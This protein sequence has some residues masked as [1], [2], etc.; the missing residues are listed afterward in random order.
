[1]VAGLR[2]SQSISD[3]WQYQGWV[4]DLRQTDKPDAIGE[5]IIQVASDGESQTALADAASSGQRQ[6]PHVGTAQE[7]THHEAFALACDEWCQGGRNTSQRPLPQVG[8]PGRLRR[9]GQVR[10]GEMGCHDLA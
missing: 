1:L 9:S 7:P 6:E 3:R 4:T 5:D 2:H 10:T 8:G